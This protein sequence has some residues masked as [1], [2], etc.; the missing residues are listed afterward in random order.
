MWYKTWKKI[1]LARKYMIL[2]TSSDKL[3]K[4]RC[5]KGDVGNTSSW[6]WLILREEREKKKDEP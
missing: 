2:F 6:N 5:T 3:L 4:D 1:R